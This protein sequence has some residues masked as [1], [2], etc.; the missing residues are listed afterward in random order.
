[1]SLP[2]AICSIGIDL[3]FAESSFRSFRDYDTPRSIG[4]RSL[5]LRRPE[6]LATGEHAR[7]SYDDEKHTRDDLEIISSLQ[8]VA[9]WL[10]RQN[11]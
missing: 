6:V 4:M 5:L 10:E 2:S 1:M 11:R 7:A 8:E 9:S 3:F